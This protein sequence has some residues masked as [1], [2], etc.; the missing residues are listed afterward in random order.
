MPSVLVEFPRSAVLKHRA[1]NN[2]PFE[3]VNVVSTTISTGNLTAMRHTSKKRGKRST[4][5]VIG[6][7]SI[8]ALAVGAALILVRRELPP[9]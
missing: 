6:A 9:P 8:S 3:H 1:Q 5:L 2:S 4:L 7:A